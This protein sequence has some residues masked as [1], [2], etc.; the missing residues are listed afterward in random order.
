M[1]IPLISMLICIAWC[2]PPFW[3]LLPHSSTSS[4][5][6]LNSCSNWAFT[7]VTSVAITYFNLIFTGRY[8]Y[9]R[10]L[11]FTQQNLGSFV[12]NLKWQSKKKVFIDFLKN[13]KTASIQTQTVHIGCKFAKL[14]KKSEGTDLGVGQAL[15]V[16]E[17]QAHQWQNRANLLGLDMKHN[18]GT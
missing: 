8:K 10:Q 16:D 18:L 13:E 14:E 3:E 2:V 1:K 9:Q 12:N 4:P 11:H 5:P 6:T 15:N 17:R 7:I